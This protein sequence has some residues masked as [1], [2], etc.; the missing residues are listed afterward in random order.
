MG[1]ATSAWQ[2]LVLT[3]TAAIVFIGIYDV[4]IG[5]SRFLVLPGLG[6][7]PSAPPAPGVQLTFSA[8]A[9][10]KGLVT[11]SGVAAQSGVM[12]ADPTLLPMGS[13]VDFAIDD[14]KYNGIYTIL[15]TGPEIKG[16]EVDVYMWS[17]NEALQ[18]GRRPAKVTILRLGW[19]P[20][21]TTQR[22]FDRLF[23]RSDPKAPLAARPLPQ[24]R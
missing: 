17:C 21:A 14:V 6:P 8:T 23:K 16:H 4:T 1:V 11:N 9:Y 18:F 2:K 12:A 5:D 24:P 3:I 22:L 20:Q 7:D 19:N 13:V 10:C 15:D